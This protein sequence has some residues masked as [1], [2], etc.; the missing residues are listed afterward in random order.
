MPVFPWSVLG[1]VP[2]AGSPAFDALLEGDLLPKDAAGGLRSVAEVIAALNGPPAVSE[3]AGQASA[4]AVFR[5][6]AGLSGEPTRS[7]RRRHPLLTSLLSVK[8]AAAAAVAVGAAATAAYAGALPAS[9]QNL[10]HDTIGAPQAHSGASPAPSA[11][12]VGP[13]ASGHAAFGLCTAYAHLKANGSAKQKAVAFRNLAAAAGGAANVTAYCAGV[14]H[15]GTTP[16][17]D[18]ASHPTGKPATLPSQAPTSHPTGGPGSH[19]TGKPSSH[20]T[21]TS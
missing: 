18:P 2:K 9:M 5:S 20:P 19:P 11:T 7:R 16:S 13:D 3:L 6:A 14:A 10:A 4:L 8:L 21:G 12:P 15:P 17:G 1:G